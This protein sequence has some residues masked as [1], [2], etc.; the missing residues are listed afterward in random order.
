[1]GSCGGILN[2]SVNTFILLVLLTG[3]QILLSMVASMQDCNKAKPCFP[4]P[5]ETACLK[6]SRPWGLE[7]RQGRR[8]SPGSW[9]LKQCTKLYKNQAGKVG[10]DNSCQ[11]AGATAGHLGCLL[12]DDCTRPVG[13]AQIRPCLSLIKLCY[14]LQRLYVLFCIQN[15]CW[16][17][18]LQV[19]PLLQ[20]CI[21]TSLVDIGKSTMASSA[22]SGS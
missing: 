6:A 20:F 16:N 15:Q 5:T 13:W 4:V 11:R 1:M 14:V 22:S 9:K 21:S 17:D 7:G 2:L 19:L 8:P 3:T 10:F 18:R 12:H